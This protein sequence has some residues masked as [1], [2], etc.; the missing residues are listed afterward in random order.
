MTR[1]EAHELLNAAR[2]GANVDKRIIAAAL[3]VTGDMAAN[4][5]ALQVKR[6][7]GT[8]E[9]RHGFNAL[10]SPATPFDGLMT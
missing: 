8:W 3:R 6:P 1:A 4:D 9:R 2:D 5:K 7:A 10:L